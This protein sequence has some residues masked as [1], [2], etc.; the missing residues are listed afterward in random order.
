MINTGSICAQ[1]GEQ[2]FGSTWPFQIPVGNICGE[3]EWHGGIPT[4]SISCRDTLLL[5]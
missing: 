1:P 4:S 2:L 5:G 3:K